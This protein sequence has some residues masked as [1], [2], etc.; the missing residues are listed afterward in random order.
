VNERRK[1]SADGSKSEKI[2]LA[3]IRSRLLRDYRRAF[4]VLTGITIVLRPADAARSPRYTSNAIPIRAGKHLIAT[5]HVNGNHASR[6]LTQQQYREARTL[7]RIFAMQ[8]AEAS[9]SILVRV[10][11]T[12]PA[13]I[14]RAKNFILENSRTNLTLSQTAR[15]LNI[16]TYYFCKLFKK[17][18]GL[19]F[20]E[21]L[22]RVRVERAKHLLLASDVRIS[23]AA[24]EAGFQSLTHFNRVFKS[25]VG[26]SPRDFRS[27][28]TTI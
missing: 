27:A 8:L 14:T 13:L 17:A 12:E 9:N 28:R 26:K 11:K 18:T 7:L 1:R 2:V 21:Y 10:K 19:T 5:M 4:K 16:S 25:L 22:C 23:E 3:L 6:A 24:F 20:S 15:A